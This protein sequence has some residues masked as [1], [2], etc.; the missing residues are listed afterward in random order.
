M[1]R[2]VAGVVLGYLA[3]AVLVFTLLTTAYFAMGADLA[4]RPGTYEISYT[5]AAV[6]FVVGLGAAIIGGL[7]CARVSRLPKPPLALAGL[8]L[9]LGFVHAIPAMTNPPT[10]GGERG[11]DVSN[12]DAMMKAKEPLWTMLVHP[13]IGAAG[14][15]LGARIKAVRA[16]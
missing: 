12:F 13:V 9:V 7:V 3:M 10:T 14:V 4:F 15:L 5:W 2:A 16:R 11:G 6:M 1:L 8:V